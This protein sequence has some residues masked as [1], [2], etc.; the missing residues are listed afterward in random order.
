MKRCSP[1]SQCHPRSSRMERVSTLQGVK[2]IEAV[3]SCD[4]WTETVCGRVS[5]EQL[6]H[7]G[8]PYQVAMDVGHCLGT[9]SKGEEKKNF[10]QYN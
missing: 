9:C 10:N 6:V 3:D 8:T 4:C 2:I 7:S 1:Q 5:F